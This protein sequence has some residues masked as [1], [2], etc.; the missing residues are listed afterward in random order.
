MAAICYRVC[1]FACLW[2]LETLQLLYCLLFLLINLAIISILI[3]SHWNPRNQPKLLSQKYWHLPVRNGSI[4]RAFWNLNQSIDQKVKNLQLEKCRYIKDIKNTFWDTAQ[5][6]HSKQQ[7]KSFEKIC[8]LKFVQVGYKKP[9]SFF[10]SNKYCD[11][12]FHASFTKCTGL[13]KLF[14]NNNMIY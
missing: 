3:S 9:K 8:S 10:S 6:F 14:L 13:A 1:S 11:L 7:R 5:Y 12:L 2:Q 4:A